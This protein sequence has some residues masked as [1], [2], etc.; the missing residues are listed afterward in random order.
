MLDRLRRSDCNEQRARVG[1]ADVLGR[2]HDHAARDEARV[3]ARLEHRR[4]VVDGG[5]GV[6]AAHRLDEGGVKS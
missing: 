1:V 5:V 4:E 3:L 6:A 2:E